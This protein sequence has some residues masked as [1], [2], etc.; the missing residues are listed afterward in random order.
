MTLKIQSVRI[1][2]DR[3]EL[4]LREEETG[5]LH[6]F[7][8]LEELQRFGFHGQINTEIKVGLDEKPNSD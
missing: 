5:A 8:I 3:M 4:L 2:Q 1:N 7:Y 6:T